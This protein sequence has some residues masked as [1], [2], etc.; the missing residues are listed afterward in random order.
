MD[1]VEGGA[2]LEKERR[3]NKMGTLSSIAHWHVNIRVVIFTSLT[4]ELVTHHV[5][6]FVEYR[7]FNEM[8]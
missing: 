1:Y 4:L 8:Y 7:S 5:F 2:P 3:P 6:K